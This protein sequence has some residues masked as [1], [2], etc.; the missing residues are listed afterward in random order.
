MTT[1][2]G[3]SD[4]G[5]GLPGATPPVNTHVH[6]APN[7]SA[8]GTAEEA[9]SAA[10][11][12]GIAVLGGSNFH[13]L[14]VYTRFRDAAVEAGIVPVFGVEIICLVDDLQRAGIR[15]NDPAVLALFHGFS[16]WGRVERTEQVDTVRLDDGKETEGLDLLKIDI[17]GAE[18]Q[19]FRDGSTD[20]LAKT[21][22]CAVECHGAAPEQAFR[23]AAT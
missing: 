12:E 5:P 10:A 18:L 2:R 15:V 8:F 20:F 16:D 3:R 17:E 1:A 22:C 7:F 6:L 23:A 9:V 21:R 4:R 13:H 19:V 14:G 11:R